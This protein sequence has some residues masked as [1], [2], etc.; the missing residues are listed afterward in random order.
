MK[1]NCACQGVPEARMRRSRSSEN[2]CRVV[3]VRVGLS[4][5]KVDEVVLTED[6]AG[7]VMAMKRSWPSFV[8]SLRNVHEIQPLPLSITSA[9][10]I[11]V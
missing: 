8:A 9:A 10:V 6:P 5:G 4:S 11:P 2:W 3:Q 7:L 1:V